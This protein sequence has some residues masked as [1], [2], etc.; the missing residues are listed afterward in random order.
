MGI[1]SK[2]GAGIAVAIVA[3]GGA[4]CSSAPANE[5]SS[6]TEQDWSTFRVLPPCSVEPATDCES[7]THAGWLA[8]Y[9]GNCSDIKVSATQRWTAND[10]TAWLNGI[11]DQWLQDNSFGLTG[12]DDFVKWM[13]E[14]VAPKFT[15]G[16]LQ[17]QPP[18][19]F[20]EWN[21]DANVAASQAGYLGATGGYWVC[22]SSR[23]STA[24]VVCGPPLP[25][26]GSSVLARGNNCP[27]CKWLP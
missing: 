6:G 4:A 13:H 27:K 11:H 2:L 7:Q 10:G 16:M 14:R 9:P 26:G 22:R 20:Y 18:T 21:D 23:I 25:W 5:A 24:D 3:L 17:G 1:A 19:C 8:I 15:M 12:D